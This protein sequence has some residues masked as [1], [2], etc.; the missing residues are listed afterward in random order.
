[1]FAGFDPAATAASAAR[2][3]AERKSVLDF[4]LAQAQSLS[5]KLSL[6]DRSR[7]DEHTTRVRNLE[8]RLERLGKTHPIGPSPSTMAC[9][10]PPRPDASPPLDFIRG[11]APSEIVEWAHG[12]VPGVDGGRDSMRHHA[13]DHLHDR[14]RNQQ[15][16]LPGPDRHLDASPRHLGT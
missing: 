6:S 5:L 10:F 1:M 3:A 11:I 15:Q 9:A 8:T 7:L 4:V 14:K 16:R 13:R 2:R 12:L